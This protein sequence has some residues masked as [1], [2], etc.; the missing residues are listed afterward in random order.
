[1]TPGRYEVTWD[2][3][4]LPSGLYF[5]RFEAGEFTDLK[6]MILMK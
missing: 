1:M 4:N 3:G 5:Y 6:K 2:A